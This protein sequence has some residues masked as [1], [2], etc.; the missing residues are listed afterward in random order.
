MSQSSFEIFIMRHL[1]S[2]VKM[3]GTL[4]NQNG[5]NNGNIIISSFIVDQTT[6]LAFI[7]LSFLHEDDVKL[8]T[9]LFMEAAK[10]LDDDIVSFF[11]ANLENYTPETFLLRKSNEMELQR[12]SS[13]QREFHR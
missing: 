2:Q 6:A 1:Y 4:G 8:Q 7:S 9:S 11:S 10:T 13:K 3:L 12:W 5:D